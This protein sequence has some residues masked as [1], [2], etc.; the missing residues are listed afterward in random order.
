MDRTARIT[1]MSRITA[2]LSMMHAPGVDLMR[3]A[4]IRALLPGISP[5]ELD[6]LFRV[7]GR[8]VR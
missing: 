4:A 5:G 7:E 6:R 2:I 1:T 3:E 8:A